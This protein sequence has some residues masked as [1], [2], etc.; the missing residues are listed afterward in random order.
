MI[1]T[2]LPVCVLSILDLLLG[3]VCEIV[4]KY[5]DEIILIFRTMYIYMC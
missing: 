4:C 2:F 3:I 5:F 1:Q